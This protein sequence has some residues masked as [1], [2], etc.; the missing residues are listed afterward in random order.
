VSVGLTV[1]MP[2]KG[3][4]ERVCACVCERVCVCER[5]RESVWG[6]PSGDCSEGRI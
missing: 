2:A 6:P 4:C 3:V 1:A 5:E